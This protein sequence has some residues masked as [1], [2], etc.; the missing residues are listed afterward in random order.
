M[1]LDSKVRLVL[2]SGSPRRRELLSLLGYPFEIIVPAIEERRV[3]TESPLA[4]V[5]RLSLEKAQAAAI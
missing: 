2:A 5:Q 1:N 4:Y 3:P